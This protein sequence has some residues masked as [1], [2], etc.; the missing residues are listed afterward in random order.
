VH[1]FPFGVACYEID[2]TIHVDAINGSSDEYDVALSAM[3]LHCDL[4]P[5]PVT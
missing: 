1:I 2:A 5:D 3:F 4:K